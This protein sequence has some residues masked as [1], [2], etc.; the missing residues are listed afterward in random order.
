[1]NPWSRSVHAQVLLQNIFLISSRKFF[2]SILVWGGSQDPIPIRCGALASLRFLV[3]YLFEF[4]P[5]ILFQLQFAQK[6]IV[7]GSVLSVHGKHQR[8]NYTSRYMHLRICV[9]TKHFYNSTLCRSRYNIS[10]T[11]SKKYVCYR[12]SELSCLSHWYFYFSF[13]LQAKGGL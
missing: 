1:M 13:A 3:H 5:C 4:V 9:G 11:I 6:K 10:Q 7:L 2:C 8:I 12:F